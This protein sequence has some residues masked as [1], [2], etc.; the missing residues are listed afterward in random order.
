MCAL[1]GGGVCQVPPAVIRPSVDVEGGA[2][3]EDDITM[4][5]MVR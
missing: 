4:K 1:T 2:S 3:N 5:L